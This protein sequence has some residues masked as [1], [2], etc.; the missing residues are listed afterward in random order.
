MSPASQSGGSQAKKP[1]MPPSRIAVIVF[2]LIAAVVIYLEL[3][4]RS[5]Q[6][7]SYKAIDAAMVEGENSGDGLYKDKVEELLVGSPSR[8]VQGNTEVLT[9]RGPLRAH[10]INITYGDGGFVMNI[11]RE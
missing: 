2:V 3:R 1:I 10:K 9:W 8:N 6:D 5:G 11:S 7:K 4:A